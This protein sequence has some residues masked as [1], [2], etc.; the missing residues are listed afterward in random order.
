MD[1]SDGGD[2]LDIG[3]VELALG[4]GVPVTLLTL[5][6]RGDLETV[7]YRSGEKEKG[8]APDALR[9]DKFVHFYDLL[10]SIGCPAPSLGIAVSP[11]A[12]C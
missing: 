9:D 12:G 7:D 2:G 8:R 1:F 4:D 5:L 10:R 3:F 6:G 11:A